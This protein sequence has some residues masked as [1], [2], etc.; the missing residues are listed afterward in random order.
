MS[1]KQ[2][3]LNDNKAILLIAFIVLALIGVA[4][5]TFGPKLSVWSR[6]FTNECDH[7]ECIKPGQSVSMAFYAPY[8]RLNSITIYMEN[9][10]EWDT[11]TT[12]DAEIFVADSDGNIICSDHISSV[13]EKSFVFDGVDLERDAVYVLTYKLNSAS[14]DDVSIGVSSYDNLAFSMKGSYSGAPTKGTFLVFYVVVSIL[15]LFYVRYYGEQ[16]IKKTVLFD[17]VLLI[18]C[19]FLS[20]ISVNMFYD[21]FM[22]GR[23]G[24]MMQN[25]IIDGQFFNFYDYAY[26]NELANCSAAVHFEHFY[27]VFTYLLI[28]ILL[29]PIRVLMVGG[30]EINRLMSCIVLYLDVI[31]ALF[32]LWSSKLTERVCKA[33]NMPDEYTASV[34]YIYAFT[35]VVIS[36]I[37]A[38]GQ[39]DIFYIILILWA[40]PFYYGGKY[41]FFSFIMAFALSVKIIPIIFFIP[42]VL[43]VNKKIKDIVINIVIGLSVTI[44]ERVVFGRSEG[45][46]ALGG[47]ISEKYGFVDRLFSNTLGSSISLFIFAYT[48]VCI[49][50]YF[51]DIDTSNSKMLLY[52]SMLS[53]FSVYGFFTVFI[54]WHTQWLVPLFLSF[55]FIAPF[56]TDKKRILIIELVLEIIVLIVSDMG[57]GMAYTIDNGLLA[58]SDYSYNGI[59]LAE[60]FMNVSPMAKVLL[61]T[62]EA[63]IIISMMYYFLKRNLFAIKG[64]ELSDQDYIVARSWSIGRIFV[65]YALLVVSFWQYSF[66]G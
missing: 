19:V 57:V 28:A 18:V 21:L 3:T 5:V 64:S 32:V 27:S 24:I 51:K 17:K 49:W 61:I 43:L 38:S 33:C 65:L 46:Q 54:E 58:L 12:T 50:C 39:I 34:K 62:L 66:V 6:S 53:M 63:G 44:I 29:I 36:A 56:V 4:L 11:V 25:A 37:V 22:I 8:D 47:L 41:R 35:S 14:T 45:Y 7:Y 9:L 2:N 52:Y 40:L 16:D 59:S 1:N 42:F 20:I 26:R 55:S 30:I 31:V 15:V 13:L 60:A 23:S 48:V 10:S